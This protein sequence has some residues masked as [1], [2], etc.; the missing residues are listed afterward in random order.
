MK[1]GKMPEIERGIPIPPRRRKG[2]GIIAL[3][4]EM[5]VND[6]IYV[7]TEQHRNPARSASYALGVSNYT[8]RKE[9][10]GIRIWRI[11]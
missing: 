10:S 3:L 9:G 5:K 7:T 2:G 8:V 11:K 1:N 6:S 4:R